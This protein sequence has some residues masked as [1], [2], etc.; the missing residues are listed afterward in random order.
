MNIHRRLARLE[1][2]QTK[3]QPGRWTDRECEIARSL[4]RKL[5]L[6]LPPQTTEAETQTALELLIR[7]RERLRADINDTGGLDELAAFA[8]A[9]HTK[10]Q[11]NSHR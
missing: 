4:Q 11:K 5:N 9:L 10:Y 6:P 7:G 3:T 2:Q 1:S 8:A